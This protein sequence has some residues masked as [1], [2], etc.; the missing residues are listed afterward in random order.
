MGA[1]E[2]GSTKNLK[3]SVEGGQHVTLELTVR[4]SFVLPAPISAE[5]EMQNAARL[6]N[7][8]LRHRVADELE[9]TWLGQEP[10]TESAEPE[11]GNPAL[12]PEAAAKEAA[13]AEGSIADPPTP[14][15]QST[16]S[17]DISPPAFNP[18]RRGQQAR[19]A[20]QQIVLHLEGRYGFTPDART[21]RLAFT[22]WLAGRPGLTLDTTNDLRPEVAQQVLRRLATEHNPD[23]LV[24]EWRAT[25]LQPDHQPNPSIIDEPLGF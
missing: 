3:V 1:R 13:P 5:Q 20:Q 14:P 6:M 2:F 15:R 7:S 4:L 24:A 17:A 21:E 18:N 25:L 11:Q 16:R 12:D 19:T 23:D 22:G 9:Q 10:E 8:S